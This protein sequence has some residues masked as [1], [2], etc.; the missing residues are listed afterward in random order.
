[1]GSG[2]S[3]HGESIRVVWGAHAHRITEGTKGGPRGRNR[4]GIKGAERTRRSQEPACF[5]K[6]QAAAVGGIRLHRLL[7]PPCPR[8]DQ[9]RPDRHTLSPSLPL[10]SLALL[11]CWPSPQVSCVGDEAQQTGSRALAACIRVVTQGPPAG[12]RGPVALGE[13]ADR[14]W[15]PVGS[16]GARSGSYFIAPFISLLRRGHDEEAGFHSFIS[17]CRSWPIRWRLVLPLLC[18]DLLALPARPEES[19]AG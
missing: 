15:M 10:S 6:H 1:M 8:T 2:P 13:R 19:S 4:R 16:A 14:Y 11:R 7:L 3:L 9:T 17:A 5:T 18:T 12:G